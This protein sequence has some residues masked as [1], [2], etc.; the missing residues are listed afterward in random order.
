MWRSTA[1]SLRPTGLDSTSV[2]LVVLP[3]VSISNVTVTCPLDASGSVLKPARADRLV[4]HVVRAREPLAAQL[5]RRSA[6]SRAFATRADTRCPSSRS[7]RT[8]RPNRRCRAARHGRRDGIALRLLVQQRQC[9]LERRDAHARGIAFFAIRV[10]D[11]EQRLNLPDVA[12]AMDVAN[13][14]QRAR[15]LVALE[16]EQQ[17]VAEPLG[18]LIDGV[19]HGVGARRDCALHEAQRFDLLCLGFA[20]L[21]QSRAASATCGRAARFGPRCVGRKRGG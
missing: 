13:D 17:S 3:A 16:L 18:I 9:I 8:R 5:R 11:P 19:E 14:A 15:V 12:V 1:S 4:Q 2:T 10:A 20:E 6:P 7:C 21:I